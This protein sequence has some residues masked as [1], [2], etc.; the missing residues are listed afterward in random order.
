MPVAPAAAAAVAGERAAPIKLALRAV[1]KRFESRS[2]RIV[3]LDEINLEIRDREFVSIVGPSGCGKTTLLRVAA[4]LEEATGGVVELDGLPAG[5][6]GPRRGMVFQRFAL[7]PHLTVRHN[8]EFGL[9]IKRVPRAERERVISRYLD[10]LGLADFG[11]AYPRE[12]S[13]GMQQRVAIARALVVEPEVLLMDEP[14]ASLD[15]QIRI[16][17]QEML[18]NLVK[19]TNITTMFVTHSV[20]EAIYLADRV[21]VLTPRPARVAKVIDIGREVAWKGLTVPEA[22]LDPQFLHLKKTVWELIRHDIGGK[23]TAPAAGNLVRPTPA[24]AAAPDVP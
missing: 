12:L 19:V 23:G 13:G 1:S 14:F 6:P 5:G 22:D 2:S 18:S 8:I 24:E 15:A 9:K 10:L 20:E 7:F 21:I 11:H 17:M 3:A 4:G 16:S